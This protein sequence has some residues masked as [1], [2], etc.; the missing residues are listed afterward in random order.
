MA[1]RAKESGPSVR[2]HDSPPADNPIHRPPGQPQC[3]ACGMRD[4]M[5]I[6]L[7][8]DLFTAEIFCCLSCAASYAFAHLKQTKLTWCRTHS[9]WTTELGRCASCCAEKQIANPKPCTVKNC[10]LQGTEVANG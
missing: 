6:K 7:S 9:C 4:A 2:A 8:G 1:K 3:L 10:P 5:D